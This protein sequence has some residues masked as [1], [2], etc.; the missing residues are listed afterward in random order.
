MDILIPSIPGEIKDGKIESSIIYTGKIGGQ[1][2]NC[3]GILM[4]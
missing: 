1:I 2:F 3:R 4:C